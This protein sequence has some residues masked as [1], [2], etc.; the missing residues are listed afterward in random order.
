MLDLD[1]KSQIYAS[2]DL[3]V[4]SHAN[5]EMSAGHQIEND[6]VNCECCSYR[7]EIGSFIQRSEDFSIVCPSCDYPIVVD[8]KESSKKGFVTLK[9]EDCAKC[10]AVNSMKLVAN[11]HDLCYVECDQ[12]HEKKEC[13]LQE[14]PFGLSEHQ[15]SINPP[16]CPKCGNHD[17]ATFIYV[18]VKGRDQVQ[19]IRCG[20][21]VDMQVWQ[22][23]VASLP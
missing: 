18:M 19:C 21:T 17:S 7:G 12:C 11:E 9:M 5:N 15:L 16:K 3:Q 20:E 6:L 22:L 10:G 8:G 13:E 14:T 2:N 1:L 4:Y 23:L